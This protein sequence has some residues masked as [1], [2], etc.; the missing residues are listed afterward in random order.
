MKIKN[1]FKSPLKLIVRAV[2]LLGIFFSLKALTFTESASTETKNAPELLSATPI[3]K[4]AEHNAFTDLAEYKGSF[5]CVFRESITHMTGEGQIRVLKSRDGSQWESIALL[6]KEGLDLR[7]PKLSVTPEGKLMLNVGGSIYRDEDLKGFDPQVSFSENGIDW[8]PF[9]SLNI[10][11]E[12]PWRVTWHDGVG[13]TMAYH[14]T[15]FSDYDQPW[16]ITLMKTEDGI[17]FTT[18]KQFN[19]PDYPNETTLRFLKDGTMVAL[20]RLGGKGLIGTSPSPYQEWNWTH[21]NQSVGGPNF[22]VLPDGTMWAVA[23]EVIENGEFNEYTEIY[24]S[25]AHMTTT[26]YE[27]LLRLPS[28]GD[29]GYAGMVYKDGILYI[30]YYTSHEDERSEIYFAEVALPAPSSKD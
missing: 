2:I 12:W 23:R 29:T 8:Y 21:I 24:T 26:T 25:V 28:G 15:D 1:F 19:Q 20:T 7:D 18:I 6:S 13:Y 5:F 17:N 4:E 22:L 3:W 27:P 10:P 14:L 16:V 11:N 9:Q 30:S